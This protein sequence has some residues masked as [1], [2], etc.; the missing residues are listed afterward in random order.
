MQ[1]VEGVIPEMRKEYKNAA[2]AQLETTQN[3]NLE[4][5]GAVT[6]GGMATHEIIKF[7]GCSFT[8]RGM[9]SVQETGEGTALDSRGK[10]QRLCHLLAC[11]IWGELTTLSLG[12]LIYKDNNT[13]CTLQGYSCYVQVAYTEMIFFM[14]KLHYLCCNL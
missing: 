14:A 7:K 1:Q 9:E 13:L 11:V 8:T 5:G 4:M 10:G 3:G 2:L 6:C 12:F